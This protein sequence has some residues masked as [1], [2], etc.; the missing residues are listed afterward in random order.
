MTMTGTL[1]AA[2]VHRV[3]ALS[4]SLRPVFRVVPEVY[5][6][7]G[8]VKGVIA[9]QHKKLAIGLAALAL[10]APVPA[11]A[12]TSV[13]AA[14]TRTGTVVSTASGPYGRVL[15]VG[16]SGAG[17][18]PAG[19]SLYFPTVDP[20]A[21]TALGTKPYRA[22]CTTTIVATP[23]G[24]ISCTGAESD[25]HADWPALTT[26]ATPVAGPG[27]DA[28]LLG[29]VY[30]ADL[31][32]YQ[33]TYAGHPL[34]L[35]DPGPHSF[36]GANFYETVLPLP[37]WHTAWFLLQPDGVPA[38][39]AANLETEAPQAGTTYSTTELAVEMLPG[40]VKGGATVSVYAFSKDAGGQSRCANACAR[41]FIPVL[42]VGTPTTAAGVDAASV[43]T[44][45]RQDGSTQV[46]YGGQPLYVYDGEQPLAGPKGLLTDGTAGN[47]SG[48]SA[49][50]GT[51]SPVT[52]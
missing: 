32:T 5:A 52:P 39:G 49:F 50:G 13:G 2:T 11:V 17:P 23:R 38:T 31:G 41:E 35:F 27:V 21:Q 20:P 9:M 26:T 22:A 8:V 48:V 44:V 16:G 42:T 36:A 24:N 10:G 47:G 37:P 25:R 15:V 30:R 45:M 19:S 40:V 1:V 14:T 33:V 4:V 6:H 29:A 34:Y 3:A 18:Y 51:L 12:A 7:P 28:Y 43:G 46:T